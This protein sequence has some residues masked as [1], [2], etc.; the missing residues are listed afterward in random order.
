MKFTEAAVLCRVRSHLSATGKRLSVHQSN[1]RKEFYNGSMHIKFSL[2]PFLIEP[3]IKPH[4]FREPC[5]ITV[6]SVPYLP[7]QNKKPIQEQNNSHLGNKIKTHTGKSE[8]KQQYLRTGTLWQLQHRPLLS[9]QHQLMEKIRITMSAGNFHIS[10]K[11]GELK[12][13]FT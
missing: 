8:K 6:K 9:C 7:Q 12:C 4:S 3:I 10:F 2:Q 11:L 13:S 5:I 1:R